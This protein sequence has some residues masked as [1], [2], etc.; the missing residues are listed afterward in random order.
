MSKK[1]PDKRLEDLFEN[2]PTEEAQPTGKKQPD[3]GRSTT[4]K[5]A[6]S[7]PGGRVLPPSAFAPVEEPAV[8]A[9]QGSAAGETPASLSLGFRLDAQNWATLQ[10]VD[11]TGPREWDPNEQLLVRQVVD[12][13]A[14]A[15]ENARLFQE[16]RLR[17]EEL[18]IL[19]EFGRELASQTSIEAIAETV[20]RYASRL[21]DTTNLFISLYDETRQEVHPIFVVNDHQRINVPPRP[22]GHGLTDYILRTRQPLYLPDDV[23]GRM[24]ALGIEFVPIGDSRPAKCWMGVPLLVGDSI[25]GV[26]AVQSTE[27]ANLYTERHRDL[28]IAIAGQTAIAIQ[29]VRSLEEIRRRAEE[30]NLLNEL[31]QRLSAQLDIQQVLHE[32]YEGVR[33]LIPVENFFIGLYNPERHEITF[34]LNVTESQLDKEVITLPADQG[35]SGYII[36]TRQP[37]FLPKDVQETLQVL[38]IQLVG[39]PAKS[40]IG[41]P[42]LLGDRVIGVMAAQSYHQEN[43]YDQHDLE[44]LQAIAGQ[45]AIALQNARLFEETRKRAQ[46][47]E[48]LYRLSH[49]LTRA[50][51]EKEIC[52][53]TVSALKE[54]LGYAFSGVFLLDPETGDRVLMAQRGWEN[55]PADWRIPPG[56][57]IS[58]R[59][60]ERGELHYCPDVSQE[61]AYLPGAQGMGSEVDVPI[62]IGDTILGVLIVEAQQP[63]AFTADDFYIL[64]SVASQLAVALQNAHLFE[65]TRRSEAELR[66]LFAAMTDVIIIYDREGRYVRIA[67]T[68]PSRLFRPSAEMLGRRLTEVLPQELHQPFLET[69]ARALETGQVQRL[70]YSLTIEGTQYWFEAS[71]SP[72]N[73]NQVIWLAHDITARKRAEEEIARFKLG[74]ECSTDAVVMTDVDGT[75][76]YVNPAFERLYGYSASEV[77]G[78]TMAIL[79]S[80]QMSPEFYQRLWATLLNK[81]TFSSE[82]INKTREGRLV[83]VSETI[84]PILNEKGEL[85]GFLSIHHDITPIKQ[86]EESLRRRNE[87]LAATAEISQ[88][89][90]STMDL[91]TIFRQTVN[92]VRDRFGFYHAGLFVVEE[93]GFNAVLQ[94]A[95]GE[96]GEEM[97]RR[98]H[99]LPVGSKSI[100]GQVTETGRPLVVNDTTTSDI[101]KFNPLLPETRSEAALPLRVGTRTIGALDIQSTQPNA[102]TED[103]IAVL[104]ILADQVAIAIDNAR[105]YQLSLQAMKEMREADRLKSQFLAN[106]S[107]ELRTPLNSI[108]GFSRVI[109]KGID[110]P[111]TELQQQDLQAIHNAGQHLLGLI[112]DILDLSRIEAGKME[113]TFDEVN[114]ADLINSVMSTVVGLVKDK[115]IALHR[116]IPA[117]LPTVRADAMRIRQV[118]LN[119]LSNAAKFT[120][121]GSITV[122]AEVITGPNG[123]PE[124]M[125]HVIDTGPGIAPEDQKKLFQPFSQVDASPTRKTGGSGLGLSI[126][127]HLVQ[128]HGGRIGVNSA[129]GQGSDFFFTLPVFR[130]RAESSSKAP[131]ERRVIL[132]I[133]DDPNVICLYERYLHPQGYDVIPL[134]DPA[135]AVEQ[136][137]QLKPYAIT[138]DIMMPGYDGWRVLRELKANEDTRHIPVII[139]SIVEEQEKGF[140]LGAADYLVKPILEDDLLNALDRLNGDGSIRDVL[141]IDD[142][143]DD[144]RLM[145]Q[146][147]AHSHRYRPILA[148]GGIEGWNAIQT[149]PPHAVILDL[150]MP[151]MDGFVILEKMRASETLRHIPVVTI[152]GG[153]LSAEQEQMLREFGQRLIQKSA[154]TEQQ[155]ISTLERALQRVRS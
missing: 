148:Q 11:E 92:L 115:P 116:E 123:H 5:A 153:D 22:L 97:L 38:G 2:F 118:L 43:R 54:I 39:E 85:M 133:D 124:V 90:T 33:R 113:L 7:R 122:K 24:K 58:W 114:L 47:Q 52:E 135:R 96:A 117:D 99:S 42:L 40:W 1:R 108:I 28:L 93:T 79:R 112:N 8:L 51:G 126:S 37:L 110:G 91:P 145:G 84:G 120:E 105:S 127:S 31:N 17:A 107:H 55:A 94:A 87:Y 144:L 76:L 45:A 82:F 109:L 141:I 60:I 138:L 20:Y 86:A 130:M 78:K 128:M 154:L 104:Q 4:R 103:D 29:N 77:L 71:V 142:N 149:S 48:A 25:L 147:I 106:M 102:F 3:A 21:M 15:L 23:P 41:V 49:A 27:T 64:Q 146:M 129:P 137:R 95:T 66:A 18:T 19:N 89:I 70:E 139:C 151:E 53:V 12:Q 88:L 67:P 83:Y 36:R 68:N 69:I 26:I 119:L 74:I 150:F 80:G 98:K 35:L 10:I 121:Q 65:E 155:L 14:Q 134:S 62:K 56:Q 152:T 125:V 132:S 16:T 143:P 61:P 57:G 73:E 44:L 111:I 13:L 9:L 46:Q 30:L 140:S 6:E 59:A 136:A 50:Q 100:V 101:H 131:A 32:I 81:Q 72:L 75:V 34:P 63:N